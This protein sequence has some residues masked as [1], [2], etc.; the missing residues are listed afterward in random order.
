M[1]EPIKNGMTFTGG[2]CHYGG[3]G[4]DQ[5]IFDIIA[6]HLRQTNY[7]YL[8]KERYLGAA[9]VLISTNQYDPTDENY[10]R[11]EKAFNYLNET[12]KNELKNYDLNGCKVT[13]PRFQVIWDEIRKKLCKE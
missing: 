8:D 5:N 11:L 12:F 2:T 7:T 3:I 1:G 4:I 9:N 6:D 13:K 10:K